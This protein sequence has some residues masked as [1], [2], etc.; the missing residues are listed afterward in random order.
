MGD[1]DDSENT[2]DEYISDDRNENQKYQKWRY[3]GR[4]L[5][6]GFTTNTYMFTKLIE[7]S[8]KKQISDSNLYL[9][10]V[11][12]IVFQSVKQGAYHQFN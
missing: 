6:K 10:L 11:L 3:F 4:I 1:P 12:Y 7:L 8:Q 5:I 2:L 9:Q